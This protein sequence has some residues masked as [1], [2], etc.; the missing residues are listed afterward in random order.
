MTPAGHQKL[1][2]FALTAWTLSGAAAGI[3][4]MGWAGVLWAVPGLI[5]GAIVH[6]ALMENLPV[7]CPRC[8]FRLRI[9][10]FEFPGIGGAPF[11]P[12]GGF[13]DTDR[14]NAAFYRCQQCGFAQIS[15]F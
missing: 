13:V 6:K 12:P 9:Q 5:V 11:D 15:R 1:C 7:R 4:T 14:Q 10:S 2:L 3:W 8:G